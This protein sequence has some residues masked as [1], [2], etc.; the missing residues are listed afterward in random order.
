MDQQLIENGVPI[1]WAKGSWLLVKLSETKTFVMYHTW[2]D[3][4]GRVPV[5][6]GTRIAAGQVKNNLKEMTHFSRV[7]AKSCPGDFFRPDGSPL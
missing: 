4:G 6:L 5:S 2:S 3:P 7:H 1:R